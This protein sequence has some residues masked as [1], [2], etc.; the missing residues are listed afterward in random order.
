MIKR[1]MVVMCSAFLILPIKRKKR[2]K[3]ALEDTILI[4]S[5]QQKDSVHIYIRKDCLFFAA[6]AFHFQFDIGI[7]IHARIIHV[8]Q[9]QAVGIHRAYPAGLAIENN[10]TLHVAI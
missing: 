9:Q 7:H 2:Q 8:H 6:R 4:A 5:F 1:C 3:I 10:D